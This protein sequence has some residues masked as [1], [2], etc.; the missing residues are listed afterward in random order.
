MWLGLVIDTI[1]FDL[2]IKEFIKQD[3]YMLFTSHCR[4]H[5]VFSGDIRSGIKIL[6]VSVA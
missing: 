3:A 4:K 6:Q 2:M 5:Q 1:L